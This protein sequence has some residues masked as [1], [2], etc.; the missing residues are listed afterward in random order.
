MENLVLSYM[1]INWSVKKKKE[2]RKEKKKIIP[3]KTKAET[4]HV[5]QGFFLTD[6]FYQAN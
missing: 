5:E 2:N 4:S 3:Q 1:D 6:V